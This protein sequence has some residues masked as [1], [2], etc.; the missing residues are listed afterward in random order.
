[1]S[2]SREDIPFVDRLAKALED[3]EV[4]ASIDRKDIYPTQDWQKRLHELIAQSDTIIFVL[5]P[6]AVISKHCIEEVD[7][8]VSLNKR[9]VP[10]VCR[11]LSAKLV[12]GALGCLQFIFFDDPSRFDASVDQLTDA[13]FV[14]LEW[15]GKHTEYVQAALRW[16][17]SA[18]SGGRLLV[19]TSLNEALH[20][21]ATR[22]HDAPLPTPLIQDYIAASRRSRRFTQNMITAIS[23]AGFAGALALAAWA[24]RERQVAGQ[25]FSAVQS[26]ADDVTIKLAREIRDVEG[27]KQDV[28]LLVLPKVEDITNKLTSLDPNNPDLLFSKS[29]LFYE[30]ARTYWY[31]GDVSNA[32]A[33]LTRSLAINTSLLSRNPDQ[34]TR[35]KYLEQRR[36]GFMQQGDIL[37]VIGKWEHSVDSFENAKADCQEIIRLAPDDIDASGKLTDALGRMGDVKR[38]AGQFDQALVLYQEAEGIQQGFIDSKISVD[39]WNNWLSWSENR[40]GD[41]LMKIT[42]HEG[43][44]TISDTGKPALNGAEALPHYRKSLEIRRYLSSTRHNAVDKRNLVWALALNGMA[45]LSIDT[46]QSWVVLEEGLKQVDGLLQADGTRKNTESLRYRALTRNFRGDARYLD[47]HL[48]EAFAEYDQALSDRRELVSIDPQNARWKRDLFYTLSRISEMHRIAGDLVDAQLYR[49]Q[50]LEMADEA[51]RSF[52]GDEVFNLA[53][54]G[55]KSRSVEPV[56]E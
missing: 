21:I 8:A 55:L 20:W 33:Y 42:N 18:R 28:I 5:S 17:Q 31:V 23:I 22:P 41:N 45:L 3:R 50:A 15:I 56:R 11:P 16:D 9:F 46:A 48:S 24:V 38:A 4:K 53:V 37:R 30:F 12:P 26:A 10:I 43:L 47:G 27:I 40:I 49:L 44:L 36:A 14:N 2:Y 32:D 29:I 52:H 39:Y 6:D 13:L 34:G 51:L 1:V 54:A 25:S 19:R 35:L 7:Y